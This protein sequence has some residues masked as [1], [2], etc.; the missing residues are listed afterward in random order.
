MENGVLIKLLS[1]KGNNF[2]K[3]ALDFVVIIL[4]SLT[5]IV[6]VVELYLEDVC[7]LANPERV[8][9]AELVSCIVD[10]LVL[11]L[12]CAGVVQGFIIRASG[13]RIAGPLALRPMC[14]AL[15][16]IAV[17]VIVVGDVG[18]F[19]AK[20]L[21]FLAEC[22]LPSLMLSGNLQNAIT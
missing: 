11:G 12:T 21:I 3:L 16:M 13:C 17:V 5:G 19:A 9:D 8:D 18:E 10:E 2:L 22:V 15:A 14:G 7:A 6:G 1:E 4:K 20:G